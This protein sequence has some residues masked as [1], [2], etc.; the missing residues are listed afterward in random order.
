MMDAVSEIYRCDWEKVTRLNVMEFL[1]IYSYVI[2]KNENQKML[3][4]RQIHSRR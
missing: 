1:S 2:A 3:I 4:E